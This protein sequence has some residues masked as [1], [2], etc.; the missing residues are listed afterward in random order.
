MG[1]TSKKCV[2]LTCIVSIIVTTVVTIIAAIPISRIKSA[3]NKD[4]QGL[5]NEAQTFNERYVS[6]EDSNSALKLAD[7]YVEENNQVKVLFENKESYLVLSYDMNKNFI[8][9]QEFDKNVLKRHTLFV[10][11]PIIAFIVSFFI[12]FNVF[13]YKKSNH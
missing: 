11:I 7:D 2:I 13:N 3:N 4:L 12:I 6:E 5:Y 1:K 8:E 10:V 9:G